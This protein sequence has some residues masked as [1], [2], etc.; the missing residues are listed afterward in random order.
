MR[1][2]RDQVA[3]VDEPEVVLDPAVQLAGEHSVA[4]PRRSKPVSDAMRTRPRPYPIAT[5]VSSDR[6]AEPKNVKTKAF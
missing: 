5:P 4:D 3:I 1:H 6:A 2:A